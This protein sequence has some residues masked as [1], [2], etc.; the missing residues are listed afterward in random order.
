MTPDPTLLPE[1]PTGYYI[2]PQSTCFYT[3]I[4]I[5]A[6]S[7][8]KITLAHTNFDR[9]QTL[10]IRGWASATPQGISLTSI[11]DAFEGWIAPAK[12]GLSVGF[13]DVLSPGKID[14][15]LLWSRG[16]KPNVTYYW[17][18]RNMENRQNGFYMKIDYLP[19]TI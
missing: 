6:N 8:V 2:I 13:Y 4:Q 5:P 12:V 7:W 14:N 19:Y 18:I 1:S 11:P 16:L 3:P 17:N 15:T 10:T 9:N